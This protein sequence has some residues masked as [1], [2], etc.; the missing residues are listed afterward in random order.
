MVYLDALLFAVIAICAITDVRDRKIYNKIIFPALILTFLLQAVLFGLDGF[1]A[2]LAGFGT[3][4][5]ILIIPYLVG[6][7]G[8]GDVKLLAVVGAIKGVVFVLVAAVYMALIGGFIALAILVIRKGAFHRLKYLF[9]SI[10]SRSQG[11]SIPMHMKGTAMQGTI[12]YGIAISGGVLCSFFLK[13]L[14]FQ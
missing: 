7:M 13:G 11:L 10:L 3:G 2:S 1:L 9:Y 5:A 14:E 8:A 4:F 6:G 12:P